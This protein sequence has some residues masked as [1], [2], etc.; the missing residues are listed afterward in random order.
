MIAK[1]Y[2]YVKINKMRNRAF[3]LIEIMLA[4]LIISLLLSLIVINGIKV[5]IMANE[6]NAQANLKSIGASL[7]IYATGHAGLYAQSDEA[8]MQYL[9][10][11][12]CISQD[13]IGIGKVGNYRYVLGYITP[14]GYDIR[15]MAV[16]SVLAEH[17]YQLVT[18][19][20]LKRSATA[21]A[22]D[23]NFVNY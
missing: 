19:A 13:F 7:E 6:A 2:N 4:V 5:R 20:V 9:V 3:T 18:G 15:A 23:T 10:S 21:A 11:S 8:N 22:G 14:L 16:N 1:C 12:G 17:N